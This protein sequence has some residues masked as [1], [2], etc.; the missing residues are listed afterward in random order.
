MS[1]SRISPCRFKEYSS[2]LRHCGEH[3]FVVSVLVL[4]YSHL[5]FVLWS[6][7]ST[8]GITE[9][10]M[11]EL[12]RSLLAPRVC[13]MVHENLLILAHA[14]H[15]RV[16]RIILICWWACSASSDICL[17]QQGFLCHLIRRWGIVLVCQRQQVS[18]PLP[19]GSLGQQTLC[20]C[21]SRPLESLWSPD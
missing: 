16:H 18:V 21:G 11:A 4:P 10:A 7:D 17:F 19:C 1:C 5:E 15:L 9:I 14:D 2:C 6:V 13:T 8:S 3:V 12:P 20:D